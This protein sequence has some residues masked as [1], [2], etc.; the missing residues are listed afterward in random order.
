[1]E[2]HDA[3]LNAFYKKEES[4][5]L[6]T[7]EDDTTNEKGT[8]SGRVLALSDGVFAVAIT[9]LV[10]TIQVPNLPPTS[11][12]I[13]LNTQ[14]LDSLL[15]LWPT[16]LG[17]IISFLVVGAYWRAHRH[18]FRHIKRYDAA[19][20]TLNLLLLLTVSFLP[21]PTGVIGRYPGSWVAVVFYALSL[22]LTGVMTFLLWWYASRAYRLIDAHLE[23]NIIRYYEIRFL[24][25]PAIFLLSIGLAFVN[26]LLPAISGPN[27]AEYSWVLIAVA[28]TIFERL[29]RKRTKLQ[30]QSLR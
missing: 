6:T 24:I 12:L 25:P 16:V 14:L 30:R 13:T 28:L 17:Y 4:F 5:Y 9:L 29:Y 3:T 21:L 10:L 18:I 7:F 22:A 2:L 20:L 19:F 1:M 8:D 27:L 26:I 15:A 23:K 11:S